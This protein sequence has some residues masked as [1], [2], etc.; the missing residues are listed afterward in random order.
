[1]G[2]FVTASAKL[3]KLM[4]LVAA[5]GVAG[6]LRR[7]VQCRRDELAEEAQQLLEQDPMV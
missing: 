5:S 2:A 1:M 7:P 6:V 3:R 4:F